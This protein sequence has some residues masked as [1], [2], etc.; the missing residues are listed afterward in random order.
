[1]IVSGYQE[2]HDL[3][4]QIPAIVPRVAR[5]GRPSSSDHNSRQ[6]RARHGHSAVTQS[7]PNNSHQE[8][9]LLVMLDDYHYNRRI[10]MR[11]I[12]GLED[13]VLK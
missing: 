3:Q 2:S 4:M 11:C 13:E 7:S 9:R 10:T 8:N 5:E 6:I 1:M 12:V